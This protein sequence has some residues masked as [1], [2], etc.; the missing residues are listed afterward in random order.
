MV[1]L[2][3]QDAWGLLPRDPRQAADV[4]RQVRPDSLMPC[5]VTLKRLALESGGSSALLVRCNFLGKPYG[6]NSDQEITRLGEIMG[7]AA[8]SGG[9]NVRSLPPGVT[10][11]KRGAAG[12]T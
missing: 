2:A 4:S 11:R 9:A 1:L 10:V 7:A 3:G 6:P 12:S 5:P 8:V